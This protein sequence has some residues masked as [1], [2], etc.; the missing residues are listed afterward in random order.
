MTI[1]PLFFPI[2]MVRSANVYPRGLFFLG[3]IVCLRKPSVRALLAEGPQGLGGRCVSAWRKPSAE[4]FLRGWYETYTFRAQNV[5]VLRRKRIR[6]GVKRYTFRSQNVYPSLRKRIRL[7]PLGAKLVIAK[8]FSNSVIPSSD[9]EQ[10][11]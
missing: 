9:Y 4:G 10:G 5:Y 2:P 3:M 8:G 11:G 6:F 7:I 1:W